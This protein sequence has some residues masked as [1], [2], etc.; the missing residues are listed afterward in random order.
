MLQLSYG[1][2]KKIQDFIGGDGR[3]G[4]LQ[5]RGEGGKNCARGVGELR[6]GC[7]KACEK[8]A[9]NYR[10]RQKPAV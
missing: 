9:G 8:S 10:W 1:L 6:G 7:G 4:V 5:G 3:A 2:C